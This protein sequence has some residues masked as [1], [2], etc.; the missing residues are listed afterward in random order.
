[1]FDLCDFILFLS[2]QKRFSNH[3]VQAY[4]TDLYQFLFYINQDSTSVNLNSVTRNDIRAWVIHLSNNDIAPKSIRRKIASLNT[5]FKWA[6]VH[7]HVNANPCKLIS[8]PKTEKKLPVFVDEK[9]INLSLDHLTENTETFSLRNNLIIELFYLTGIRLSELINI[10]INDIDVSRNEIRITGKRNKQRIIPL[11]KPI[12]TLIEDYLSTKKEIKSDYLF[13][14]EKG[15][16]LY[17]KLV[18]RIVHQ[19]LETATTQDKKSPHVLRHTFA[20]HLL[21]NGADLNA[22]KELL[23]H[24]GLAAT[25]VY[26]HNS[27]EKLKKVYLQAHPRA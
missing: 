8:L 23:G 17:P 3:T 26:T 18:Y 15:E 22:I 7:Q 2:N 20:T 19:F 11:T 5:L 6:L 13:T 10:K 1:M 21:N 27:Y 24:A 12:I 9:K 16:P 4:K 14:T 25:Q